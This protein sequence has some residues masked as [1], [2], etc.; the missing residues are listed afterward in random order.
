MSCSQRSWGGVGH[1]RY[2]CGR[3]VRRVSREP[4]LYY[5]ATID[6]GD[7]PCSILPFL[8]GVVLFGFDAEVVA[9]S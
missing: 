7:S 8:H 4:S 5:I 3:V 6:F 9:W 2:V 1:W